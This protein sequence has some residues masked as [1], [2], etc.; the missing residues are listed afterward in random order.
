MVQKQLQK[1]LPAQ[2]AP[3]VAAVPAVSNPNGTVPPV[4]STRPVPLANPAFAAGAV[5]NGFFNPSAAPVEPTAK[6]ARPAAV[7]PTLEEKFVR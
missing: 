4:A 5:L 2:V 6:P 1:I 7:S 3:A